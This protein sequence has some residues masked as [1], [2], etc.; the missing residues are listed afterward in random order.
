[1]TILATIDMNP[2]L[3]F[4]TSLV[5]GR[6][7]LSAAALA[8]GVAAAACMAT[9]A[10]MKLLR[11]QAPPATGFWSACAL[12][13]A[14]L[15]ISA[16]LALDQRLIL[17]MRALAWEGHWYQNRRWIQ[18]GVLVLLLPGCLLAASRIWVFASHE[19]TPHAARLAAAGMFV[20]V[21]V[22]LL[23]AVS[24]HHTDLLLDWRMVGVSA[25][26]WIDGMALA[27]VLLGATRE[28]AQAWL[29]RD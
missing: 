15:A 28:I 2:G 9:T 18:L 4:T 21:L 24:L 10:T 20:L 13:L 23:R 1:M 8:Y 16:A 29:L 26:R 3:P 5:S 6:A 25:G 14:L 11:K 22:Q 27:L 19:S 12:L 17:W 7:G